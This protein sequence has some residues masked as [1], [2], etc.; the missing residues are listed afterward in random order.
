MGESL[1][2]LGQ[3]LR[4]YEPTW[5]DTL[6]GLLMGDDPSSSRRNFVNGL[7][8]SNGLGSNGMS[9]NDLTPLGGLFGL[10]E[11]IRD[12]NKI[13]AAFNAMTIVPGSVV[14]KAAMSVGGAAKQIA[15]GLP[16]ILAMD[17]ASRMARAESMGFRTGMPVY[18]GSPSE[19]GEFRATPTSGAGLQTP[20]VSVA[21]DPS[22]ANEFA[23]KAQQGSA[24]T[25][26]Q[27][28]PLLHRADRPAVLILDGTEKQGEVASTLAQAFASGHDAVMIKNYT[29]PG[30]EAG[31]NIIIVKEPSQ[32]RSRFAAFDPSK[33][34]SAD[35]LAGASGVAVGGGLLSKAVEPPTE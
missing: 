20:G 31:K 4:P 3:E 23:T 22:V 9:L 12:H 35:L 19:F 17:H 32:L 21:M 6:A 16:E 25:S 18:H 7:V 14:G 33:K 28:Y 11:S 30:G 26:P 34:S 15:K 27:V 1:Y 2:G 13:G 24:Q 5:R 29:T 8:G 10:Q